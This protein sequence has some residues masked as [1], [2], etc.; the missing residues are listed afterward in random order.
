MLA[1]PI[2]IK[3]ITV[4]GQSVTCKVFPCQ[5]QDLPGKPAFPR[6]EAAANA[7]VEAFGFF[8]EQRA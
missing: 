8:L 2:G 6:N 1:Q 4:N 5:Y 7:A 3:T